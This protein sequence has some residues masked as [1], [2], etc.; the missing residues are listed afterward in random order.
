[1][2]RGKGTDRDQTR[3][4]TDVDLQAREGKDSV[5][6]TGKDKLFGEGTSHEVVY[7]EFVGR[8]PI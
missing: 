3:G 1:M 6:F 4:E 5:E 8:K 2:K 7:R